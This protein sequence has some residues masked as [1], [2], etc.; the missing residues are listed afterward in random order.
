MARRLSGA[1][2][3]SRARTRCWGGGC[4]RR[5][6][7]PGLRPARPAGLGGPRW[8]TSLAELDR[9]YERLVWF[10]TQTQDLSSSAW[11]AG[12]ETALE[13][14]GIEVAFARRLHAFKR[15]AER[16][17]LTRVRKH[18]LAVELSASEQAFHPIWL[19][20]AATLGDRRPL[21]LEDLI[22][23]DKA[24]KKKKN[25]KKK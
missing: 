9:P 22:D 5:N 11:T 21:L 18:L 20:T 17:G 2:V 8:I 14:A 24:P 12:E 10:G 25:A 13:A 4:S 1:V 6:V 23:E 19:Q 7:R 15:S 16:V 3:F